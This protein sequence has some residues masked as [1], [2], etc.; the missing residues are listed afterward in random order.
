MSEVIINEKSPAAEPTAATSQR[1]YDI[2]WL[3]TLAMGLLIIY[4][5]VISF[6]SVGICHW[7]SPK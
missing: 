5:V 4:H 3:R 2:D 1:R 6:Q 7:L